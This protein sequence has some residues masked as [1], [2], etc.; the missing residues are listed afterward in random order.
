MRKLRKRADTGGVIW[1]TG[2]TFDNERNLSAAALEELRK[3][4]TDAGVTMLDGD[5]HSWC[6]AT[7]SPAEPLLLTRQDRRKDPV[8]ISFD[9]ELVR[10]AWTITHERGTNRESFLIVAKDSAAR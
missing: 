1:V 5:S 3:I 10:T 8:V 7:H 9:Q 4:L 6:F 2:S